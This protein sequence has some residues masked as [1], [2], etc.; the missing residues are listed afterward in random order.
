MKCEKIELSRSSYYYHPKDRESADLKWKAKI[1]SVIDEFDGYGYRR[2]TKEL[3]R[4]G[5]Q[6]NHKK[7]LRIMNKYDLTV[8]Q[9]KRFRISTTDS[10]H[11]LKVYP[12]LAK[13]MTLTDINQLW[14]SDIT[15][16][17]LRD[18][19]IYLAIVLDAFS[20][21]VIGY[22]ISRKIDSDLTLAAIKMAIQSR[23]DIAGCIHHSDRGVQYACGQ[24]VDLLK[25]YKLEISMSR[26]GNPYDNAKAESFMKTIKMESV[27]L[28]EYDSYYDAASQIFKFIHDVYNKKRLHSSLGYLPPN[29][30]EQKLG[31][32][33]G[34]VHISNI[35]KNID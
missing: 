27:Y 26:K 5:E 4:N 31:T 21:R 14:V 35:F 8:Q 30:F 25:S 15:Y 33:K 2:I 18:E 34:L 1:E 9:R 19:F 13:G 12:N 3:Q 10:N 17:R 29:E 22:A 16:I 20:R 7:V 28:S 24:Y 32:K 6:I 11:N 23:S